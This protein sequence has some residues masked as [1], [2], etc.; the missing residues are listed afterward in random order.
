MD[1]LRI[2]TTLVLILAV[3]IS[4]MA[5]EQRLICFGNEPS[6]SL[7][8]SDGSA[9]RFVV[10]DKPAVTY[11][12]AE[13]RIEPRKESAWRGKAAGQRRGGELVAFLREAT[14]SDGMSDIKHPVTASVSLPD[15]RLYAGCCRVRVA[16]DAAPAPV[17][18]IEG[19]TWRLVS[20]PGHDLGTLGGPGRQVTVRFEAGRV[21]GFSGCNR[22]MGGYTVDR[23]HLTLGQLAGTLMACPGAGMAVESAFKASLA[24]TLRYAIADNRLTLTPA[25]GA[26]LLFDL[27]PT[28]TLEGVKWEVSGFNNGRQAVV[29]TVTGTTLTLSFQS[30][31]VTGSSGCNTYRASYKTDGKRI[32]I[33]PVAVTRMTCDG[34]GV[35]EQEREFLAALE[36]AKKWTIESGMLDV[37]RADGERVL[38]ASESLK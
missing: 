17:A 37:H 21:Q 6:W 13:T 31:N 19:V 14:C 2:L 4:P 10:P 25:S 23:D 5:A 7:E 9:A 18:T 20:L 34:K 15:G 3:P 29:G 1:K 8:F 27:E 35:M 16:P 11:R 38:T 24:G 26:P 33:G 36:T 32:F 28:A 22:F 30:G 12:G